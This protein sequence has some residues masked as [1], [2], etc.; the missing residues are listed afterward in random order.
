[1]DM[2]RNILG[3]EKAI[4]E[5]CEAYLGYAGNNYLPFLPFATG[6]FFEEADV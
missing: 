4:A 1:M 3:D 6:H 2:I 5:E